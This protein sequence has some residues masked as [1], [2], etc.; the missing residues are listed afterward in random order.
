MRVRACTEVLGGWELFLLWLLDW[1]LYYCSP[2]LE[3][4]ACLTRKQVENQIQDLESSC[5][6]DIFGAGITNGHWGPL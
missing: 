4:T 1:D 2:C 5:P 6:D 3:K